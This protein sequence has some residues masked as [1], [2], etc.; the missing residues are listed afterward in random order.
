MSETL[1]NPNQ[2]RDG[3]GSKIKIL[4][5]V[6]VG[7]PQRNGS[8]F[9]IDVDNYLKLGGIYSQGIL[10]LGSI[11]EYTLPLYTANSWKIEGLKF[12][13]FILE[14]GTN[15]IL[16][17]TEIEHYGLQVQFYGTENK[18][19]YVLGTNGSWEIALS[20][21][22]HELSA[23]TW[24]WITAEFT[25]SAYNFYVS[26][27]GLNYE[28]DLTYS[29]S[30][31]I[32]TNNTFFLGRYPRAGLALNGQIDVADMKIEINNEIVWNAVETL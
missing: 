4:N 21:G 29:S 20:A 5:V 31:K 1:I 23:N 2:I 13:Y 3:I 18:L 27:D 16:D 10:C 12:R 26:S 7:I 6:Q 14:S 15:P 9:N 30:D 8:V 17:N 22:T 19:K 11:P 25:G 32:Q 24:Y 28:L